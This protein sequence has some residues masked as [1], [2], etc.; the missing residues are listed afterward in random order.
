MPDIFPLAACPCREHISEIL[1]LSEKIESTYGKLTQGA[2]AMS[3]QD[4]CQVI[5]KQ[6][7][8]K[9]IYIYI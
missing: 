3:P 6:R 5:D 7:Q 4:L 8:P 1:L 2:S 9:Y